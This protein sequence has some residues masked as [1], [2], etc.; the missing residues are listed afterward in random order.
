MNTSTQC[1]KAEELLRGFRDNSPDGLL[2][3]IQTQF[4]LKWIS[5]P[6][7]TDNLSY[8]HL[9]I[10]WVDE[11]YIVFKM[12]RGGGFASFFLYFVQ[13]GNYFELVLADEFL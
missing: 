11:Q 3:T 7:K 8:N 5:H 6:E 13:S 9:E 1:K 2:N 10:I 12:D 4:R